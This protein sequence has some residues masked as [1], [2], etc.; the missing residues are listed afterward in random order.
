MKHDILFLLVVVAIGLFSRRLTPRGVALLG[1]L[2]FAL[3]M[4]MWRI[5]RS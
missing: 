3:I 5:T 4:H 2:V 1:V